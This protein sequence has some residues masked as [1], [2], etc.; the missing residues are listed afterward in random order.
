M[1]DDRAAGSSGRAFAYPDDHGAD[2]VKY[3]M[4]FAANTR[5]PTL[6][7]EGVTRASVSA[8]SRATAL[9]LV[10]GVAGGWSKLD[11]AM[12]LVGPYAR[13]TRHTKHGERTNVSG[14]SSVPAETIEL[15]LQTTRARLVAALEKAVG[16][17]GVLDF[18]DEAIDKGF[19]RRA[20]DEEGFEVWVPVDNARMRLEDRVGSLF[21]A[22]FLND[23]QAYASLYVCPRCESVVFEEGARVAGMCSAHV[24]R[25]GVFTMEGEGAENV[26][27]VEP[28][29]AAGER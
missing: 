21:A 1:N 2:T 23:P 7:E 14:R 26:A 3:V 20:I 17:G 18:A 10:A 5:E 13:A 6:L 11:L 12:W 29:L 28:A 24:R 4:V 9:E 15:I 19:V 22:D 16:S 25:S 8:E 27:D